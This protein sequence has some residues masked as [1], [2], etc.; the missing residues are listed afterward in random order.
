MDDNV[1]HRQESQAHIAKVNW[2][3]LIMAVHSTGGLLHNPFGCKSLWILFVECQVLLVPIWL[4][5]VLRGVFFH[6]SLHAIPEFTCFEQQQLDYVE[7]HLRLVAVLMPQCL[8]KRK[9]FL[10]KF[11]IIFT[12]NWVKLTKHSTNLSIVTI[13]YFQIMSLTVSTHLLTCC[14]PTLFANSNTK[15]SQNFLRCADKA[16]APILSRILHLKVN[17]KN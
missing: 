6:K 3:T 2:Q 12:D 8:L 9:L 15:W 13:L 16:L 17:S 5:P 14:P 1:E 10:I 7:A 11:L 4:L